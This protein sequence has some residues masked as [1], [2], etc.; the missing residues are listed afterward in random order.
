MQRCFPSSLCSQPDVAPAT[1]EPDTTTVPP[2]EP[3]PA[4]TWKKDF[5][6][7]WFET[8]EEAIS[9]QESPKDGASIVGQGVQKTGDVEGP[10][11]TSTVKD[12]S[13]GD[14]GDS[15]TSGAGSPKPSSEVATDHGTKPGYQ[16]TAI[17]LVLV[18]EEL[19]LVH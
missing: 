2:D 17:L 16:I 9:D 10:V 3:D 19:L 6:C 18:A 7:Q 12:S 4:V 15:G 1:E 13:L 8:S 5:L 11:G 14:T